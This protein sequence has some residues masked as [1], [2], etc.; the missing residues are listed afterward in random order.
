MRGPRGAKDRTAEMLKRVNELEHETAKLRTDIFA[1]LQL[2]HRIGH[3]FNNVL[4]A[5]IGDTERVAENQFDRV[6]ELAE[7]VL[8]SASR[9]VDLARE[10][11]SMGHE[12]EGPRLSAAKATAPPR[13]RGA[14]RS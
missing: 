7:A 3:D 10:L 1:L 14:R 5:I 4:Q 9:G 6:Q 11:L 8:V 13:G 2:T 12:G